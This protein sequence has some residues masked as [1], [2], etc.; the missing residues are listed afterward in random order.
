[1]ISIDEFKKVEVRAGKILLAENIE[2]SDKLLR[3]EVDFGP[4]VAEAM[5]GKEEKRDIRQIISGIKKY[6]PD[7]TL[8]VGTTCAFVTN[9]EPRE[10]MGLKSEAMIMATSGNN[11][12]EEFFSLLKLDCP[13]GSIVK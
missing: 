1:M 8:L 3:L 6:F 9:L 5:T 2:G 10:M 13:P 12:S 4:A 7:P 11:E